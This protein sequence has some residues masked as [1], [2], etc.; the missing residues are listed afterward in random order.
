M[1]RY[2]VLVFILMDMTIPQIADVL[3]EFSYNEV[4]DTILCD[5]EFNRHGRQHAQKKLLKHRKI[6]NANAQ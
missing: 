3:T 2:T 6:K 1:K 4:Y 5:I